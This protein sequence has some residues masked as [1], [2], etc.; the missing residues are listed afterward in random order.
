[1]N[2][3]INEKNYTMENTPTNIMIGSRH[4]DR[5]GE[6]IGYITILGLSNDFYI[7]PTTGKRGLKFNFALIKLKYTSKSNL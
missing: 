5:T 7:C 6:K 3:I 2:F 1:M 4:I